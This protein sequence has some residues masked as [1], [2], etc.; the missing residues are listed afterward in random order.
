MKFIKIT[1]SNIEERF[2]H[3]TQEEYELRQRLYSDDV[4]ISQKAI[5]EVFGEN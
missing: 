5:K 4:E 3:E 1:L 2:A